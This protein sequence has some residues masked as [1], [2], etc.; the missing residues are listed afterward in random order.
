[1][2][3]KQKIN[4]IDVLRAISILAVLIIH[5]TASGT[6]ELSAGSA[7]RGI[8]V[9]LNKLS[10]FS[11]PAF[12]LASGLVLFY[13]YSGAW[14]RKQALQFYRKRLQY[15]VVPY[16]I[17]SFFYMGYNAWMNPQSGWTWE[18]GAVGQHLLWGTASYHLYFMV[19]MVQYY[20]LFPLLMKLAE[21]RKGWLL[22]A[23]AIVCQALAFMYHH[24]VSPIPH[25]SAFFFT[26][27]AEFA[28]G[29]FVGL[30]YAKIQS[31]LRH[32]WR[33]L[34][35][36]VLLTG[37]VLTGLHEYNPARLRY[38]LP[39]SEVTVHAYAVLMSL[40]LLG[41]GQLLLARSAFAAKWISYLGAASFGIY[42]VHPALLT[43]WGS[44]LPVKTGTLDYYLA[45]AG[46][47]LFI[48]IASW[49]L[50]GL[51]KKGKGASILFGK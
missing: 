11:V 18:A 45:T 5:V 38:G 32:H 43:A 28:I 8:Y 17:W 46:G 21:V 6:V 29:G 34:L 1:M 24:G 2:Q 13:R 48:G 15:I 42:F 26:Y 25:R 30:H 10:N 50:V 23:A 14:D 22:P 40:F 12:I 39:L 27:F 44:W 33:L 20:V 41:V 19:L 16:L 7:G 51:V 4:E 37:T 35:V 36:G 47:F 9:A 49:I 3:K 31:V